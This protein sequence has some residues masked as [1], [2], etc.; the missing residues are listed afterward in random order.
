LSRQKYLAYVRRRYISTVQ[1]I[2]KIKSKS[3]LSKHQNTKAEDNLFVPLSIHN[4]I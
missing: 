2:F 4:L 1:R 3:A